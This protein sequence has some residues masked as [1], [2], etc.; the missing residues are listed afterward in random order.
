[1]ADAVWRPVERNSR[2]SKQPT[3]YSLHGKNHKPSFL[4]LP[5]LYLAPLVIGVHKERGING[6]LFFICFVFPPE[7]A[8]LDIMGQI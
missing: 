1:M 2:N 6:F 3:V 4:S 7:Q 5:T 8:L